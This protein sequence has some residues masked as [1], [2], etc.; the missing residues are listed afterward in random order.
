MVLAVFRSIGKQVWS[1]K[2]AEVVCRILK[3]IEIII[4][5]TARWHYLEVDR[6]FSP[7]LKHKLETPAPTATWPD[8]AAKRSSKGKNDMCASQQNRTRC[9]ALFRKLFLLV[10][11][12]ICGCILFVVIMLSSWCIGSRVVINLR[13]NHVCTSLFYVPIKLVRPS[14]QLIM[15]SHVA[16]TWSSRLPSHKHWKSIRK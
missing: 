3:L 6:G 4:V 10:L 1:A 7:F 16:K 12:P 9:Q 11:C 15:Q 2:R 8:S 13:S 5:Y 14:W